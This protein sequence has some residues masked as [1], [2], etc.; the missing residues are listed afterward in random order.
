MSECDYMHRV[1]EAARRARAR[2]ERDGL[3]EIELDAQREIAERV[4][5]A[6]TQKRHD[7][8]VLKAGNLLIPFR[9]V[10]SVDITAIEEAKAEITTYNGEKHVASGFDAIEAVMALK[11]SAMEGRRLRWKKGAWAF[12][13]LVGHP[14]MQILAWLGFKRSAIWVHD[15]TTPTPRGPR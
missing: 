5:R 13:N 3:L 14:V 7:P 9:E 12:H 8:L 15:A 10:K 2:L 1:N 6:S 4:G 11:P